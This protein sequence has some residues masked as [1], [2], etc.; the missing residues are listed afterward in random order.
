VYSNPKV[1]CFSPF[2]LIEFI[3]AYASFEEKLEENEGEFEQDEP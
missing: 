2:N 3:G 1:S